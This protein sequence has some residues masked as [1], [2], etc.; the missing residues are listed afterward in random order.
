M[1]V[2]VRKKPAPAVVSGE[3][4]KKLTNIPFFTSD[5]GGYTNRKRNKTV[6]S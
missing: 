2:K 6:K 4:A 3:R 1:R 5:I